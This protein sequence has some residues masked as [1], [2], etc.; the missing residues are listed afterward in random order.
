MKVT[1]FYIGFF[2]VPALISAQPASVHPDSMF[3]TRP[4]NFKEW[5][6]NGFYR[7]DS[8][9]FFMAT[10]YA[11]QKL[12]S[13]Y[14]LASGIG[15]AF[16]SAPVKGFGLGA[17]VFAHT[18]VFGTDI[19]QPD[20][21]TGLQNRYEV[22]LYD[23]HNIK[24]K[25]LFRPEELYLY[26]HD[27]HLRIRAGRM[28]LNTPMI[29]A[30]DGRMRASLVQGIYSELRWSRK[31]H[32][33]VG[34]LNAFS[35]RGTTQ[36]FNGLNSVGVYSAGLNLAGKR[37]TYSGTLGGFGVV[38][39]G[40]SHKSKKHILSL[41]NYYVD[42]SFNTILG[43]AEL[44][45]GSKQSWMWGTMLIRQDRLK[46]DSRVTDRFFESAISWAGSTRIE[47]EFDKGKWRMNLNYTR[48]TSHGRYLFP[49]EWG[50]DP[51]YTFLS[52][53]R[54]EGFGNLHAATLGV[55]RTEKKSGMVFSATGGYVK[56]PEMTAIPN[57]NKYAQSSYWQMNLAARFSKI[58]NIKGLEFFVLLMTK[59][60]AKNTEIPLKQ[61]YNR[62]NYY[63]L[64]L[65]V[66]YQLNNLKQ[67][68]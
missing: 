49:R 5:V 22:G 60:Q 12:K 34:L 45:F 25:G 65:V 15:A 46:S 57:L 31:M 13:D 17:S 51:F 23:L 35:P 26:Y 68:I 64:N 38:L 1:A 53:E 44:K 27:S 55:F 29:N 58:R 61:Q 62:L 7:I 19:F 2:L 37:S 6:K 59:I 14:T 4:A 54:N 50:R 21:S 16:V 30:Q 24:N 33:T 32:L 66:N 56:T 43:Q 52:R 41:W 10:G 20:T 9:S 67:K 40:V 48:I 8:R 3:L 28:L 63:H 18:Q 47:R 42:Q 39:A 36:W 11:E